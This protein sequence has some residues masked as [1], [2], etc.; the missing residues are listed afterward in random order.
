MQIA[1]YYFNQGGG[2]MVPILVILI[3]GLIF[4]GERLYFLLK[5]LG[6]GFNFA[7]KVADA[8]DSSGIKSGVE[9]SSE[10]VGPVSNL[11][12]ETI[13]KA[14]FGVEEAETSMEN[15]SAIE[16]A[17]MEKNMTWISLCIA[18]APMIGFLG[19]VV[20]MIQAFDD[21]KAAN[22]ISPAVVAGGISVALLTTAFG[23]I[24]A[25]ILQLFQN[26]CL[27]II[28]LQIVNMQKSSVVI[29]DSIKSKFRKK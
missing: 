19:T 23:L 1:T 29:M 27:Y 15:T 12:H 28:D 5:G 22:D 7:Q 14:E 2:F 17:A 13:S 18:T 20:G 21:I 16:M 3:I 6:Y 8:V 10:G 24:A 25:V 9:K 4:V 11:C 26:L